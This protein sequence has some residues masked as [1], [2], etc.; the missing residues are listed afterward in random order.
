MEDRKTAHKEKALKW[1][2]TTRL[3][4]AG[5]QPMSA[6]RQG[7]FSGVRLG[8]SAKGRVMKLAYS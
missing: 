7:W 8:P 6:H 2:M 4:P 3:P 1:E 5:R